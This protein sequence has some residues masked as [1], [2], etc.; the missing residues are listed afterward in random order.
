M[1]S[2]SP[3][4]RT[5][6]SRHLVIP[7]ERTP[8]KHA[9]PQ[10]PQEILPHAC[11]SSLAFSPGEAGILFARGGAPRRPRRGSRAA[12]VLETTPHANRR[13][14]PPIQHRISAIQ[15]ILQPLRSKPLH[16]PMASVT[17]FEGFLLAVRSVAAAWISLGPPDFEPGTFL[18]KH[19]Q[20][21]KNVMCKGSH[22]CLR[23]RL[24]WHQKT[25]FYSP[26]NPSRKAIPIRSPTRFL[27]PFSTPA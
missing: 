20:I 12:R 25:A 14:P 22:T 17:L 13:L 5:K 4:S 18:Q 16:I 27:T 8:P 21:S 9:A 15:L 1:A 6:Y 2:I 7:S 3:V 26:L 11:P 23:R 19:V 10:T 24:T